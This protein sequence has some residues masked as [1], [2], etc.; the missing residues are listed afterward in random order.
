MSTGEQVFR[1]IQAAPRSAA[2]RTG[3]PAPTQEY[4]VRHVLESFLDRLTRTAHASDFVLKGGV[5]LAVYGARRPTKDADANAIGADVSADHVAT[6]VHDIAHVE[7]DDG[8]VLDTSTVSVQ[9][10]REHAEYPGLRVRA[11]VTV[12]P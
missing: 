10:I 11:A 12:G 7:V 9:E 4:L 1:R 3:G 8:L 6:V 5:L 2:A